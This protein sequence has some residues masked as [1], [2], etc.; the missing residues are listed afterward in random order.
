MDFNNLYIYSG[1][2]RSPHQYAYSA[3]LL[4]KVMEDAGF[5]NLTVMPVNHPYFPHVID[6]QIGYTGFKP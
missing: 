3:A 4:K 2:Q 6:W 1:I 5:V